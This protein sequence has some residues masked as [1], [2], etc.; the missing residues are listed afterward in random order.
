MANCSDRAHAMVCGLGALFV[1]SNDGWLAGTDQ[2]K[3]AVGRWDHGRTRELYRQVA[4]NIYKTKDGRWYSLHGNMDPTP[5][6]NM[7]NVPQ[8][9]EKNLSWPE[10]LQVYM[11]IVAQH[12]SRTLD[13]WSNN[14]YRVPGTICYEEEEFL[15]TAHVRT[16]GRLRFSMTDH[17]YRGKLSR[18]NHITTLSRIPTRSKLLCLGTAFLRHR[19]TSVRYLASRC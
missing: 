8:H 18:T 9:N 10:I 5:L 14:I 6:L 3:A 4:T 17:R 19:Q 16:G 1:R 11:D 12:D 7:L 2:M 15:A 13:D